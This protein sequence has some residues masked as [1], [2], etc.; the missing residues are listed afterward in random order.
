M[1]NDRG[2]EMHCVDDERRNLITVKSD[3]WS[4]QQRRR[5]HRSEAALDFGQMRFPSTAI[6]A[7]YGSLRAYLSA[8][9]IAGPSA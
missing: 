2:V 8:R 1:P 3:A 6:I 5:R 9:N 7:A 4:K